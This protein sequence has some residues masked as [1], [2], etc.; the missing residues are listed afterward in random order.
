MTITKQELNQFIQEEYQQLLFEQTQGRSTFHAINREFDKTGVEAALSTIAE[1]LNKIQSDH[2][3]AEELVNIFN[4]LGITEE[5]FE[6]THNAVSRGLGNVEQEG[7][8][9]PDLA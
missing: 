9:E 7:D 4:K 6:R 1:E 8:P 5:T 2:K 3:L